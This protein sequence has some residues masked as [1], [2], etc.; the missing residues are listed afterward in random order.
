MGGIFFFVIIVLP[1]LLLTGGVLVIYLVKRKRALG[2]LL[3]FLVCFPVALATLGWLAS[4][5]KPSKT[6]IIGRYEID[7]SRY[8][9][10]QADWQ[11][12]TYTLEIRDTHVIVRDARTKKIWSSSIV[13][14]VE[15]EYRWNITDT[16]K[17]HHL[18]AEGPAI[19]REP[20]GYYYVFHSP[21]YGDVFFKKK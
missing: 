3:V 1:Y 20:F 12:A 9:G 2:F 11:N 15:P 6:D 7:R 4:P 18:I 13:W 16:G 21:L 10:K 8:P 5:T 14:F 17:R 19:Y